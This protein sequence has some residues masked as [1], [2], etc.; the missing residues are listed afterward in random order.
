MDTKT[1]EEVLDNYR[2]SGSSDVE[3]IEPNII[4]AMEEYASPLNKRI[5]ELESLV[6]VKG[7]AHNHDMGCFCPDCGRGRV[8]KLRDEKIKLEK[9]IEELEA[10]SEQ[11]LRFKSSLDYIIGTEL[12][13]PQ[14][15]LT[16]L[17]N[18]NEL[19]HPST[20]GKQD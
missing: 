9:R 13:Y 8:I 11:V 12:Q 2:C 20:N 16:A 5:E 19:L 4:A 6:Q 17:N 10:A 7:P 3:F 15:C 18:L 14:N 1:A